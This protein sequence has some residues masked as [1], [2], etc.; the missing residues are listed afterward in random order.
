MGG[1]QG[2]NL[3]ATCKILDQMKKIEGTVLH[4]WI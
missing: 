2:L 1:F 3:N 4:K